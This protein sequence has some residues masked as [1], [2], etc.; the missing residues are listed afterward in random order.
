M[1]AAT[2]AV[3]LYVPTTVG[4]VELA[5]Y[6]VDPVPAYDHDTAPDDP[7]TDADVGPTADPV[8][9]YDDDPDTVTLD[10]ARFTVTETLPTTEL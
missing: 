4:R 2:L 8:Y 1:S 3:A 5:L 6:D 7:V 10:D 9:V